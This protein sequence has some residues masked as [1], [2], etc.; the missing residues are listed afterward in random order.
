METAVN[1]SRATFGLAS[2]KDLREMP[3]DEY[4]DLIEEINRQAREAKNA[5]G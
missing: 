5:E 4:I 1:I 3:V 2:Y